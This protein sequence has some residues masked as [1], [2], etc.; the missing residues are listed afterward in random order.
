MTVKIPFTQGTGGAQSYEV[1]VLQLLGANLITPWE[2][3][4]A[5][6]IEPKYPLKENRTS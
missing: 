5:L 3:R 2:A 4:E 1:Y 6:G